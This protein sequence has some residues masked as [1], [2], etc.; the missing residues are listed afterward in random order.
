M[1]KSLSNFSFYNLI[2]HAQFGFRNG[3]STENAIHNF[4][5]FVYIAL[6][7][8]EFT[9]CTMLDLTKAF[10]TLNRSILLRNLEF[11]DVRN[12]AQAWFASYF[13]N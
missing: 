13:S 3:L 6:D 4:L 8:G 9:T 11:Y 12:V 10:D 1:Y 5:D 2:T 7:N